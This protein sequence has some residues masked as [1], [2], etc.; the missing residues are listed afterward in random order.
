[1]QDW[2]ILTIIVAAAIILGLVG[3]LVYKQRRSHHLRR[4]FG[5]EYDRAVTELGSRNRAETEL[6][7]REQH[8]RRLDIR[9][10]SVADRQKFAG[11]WMRCQT[12]FV[13]DPAGAV[14]ESE[15]ILSEIMRARGYSADDPDERMADISAAYPQQATEYRRANEILDRHHRDEAST[16]DLREA[17][18]H[19]R[20]LFDQ[21]LG[22]YD[23]ELK[24]AS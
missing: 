3:W 15:R 13:D 17:F 9:P 2:Q 18:I 6:A 21:I 10:L 8:V 1:M 22:G 5:S 19:Y 7:K 24:R 12:L 11:Q 20:V 23:E 4:H 16:E 14:N